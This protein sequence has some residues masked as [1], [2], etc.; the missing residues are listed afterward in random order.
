M[1]QVTI[2]PRERRYDW[3]I[4][5]WDDFNVIILYFQIILFVK[6]EIDLSNY[7]F[8]IIDYNLFWDYKIRYIC[9]IVHYIVIIYYELT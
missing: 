8:A 9:E 5:K 6:Y 4:S 3:N 2:V 7:F 1:I